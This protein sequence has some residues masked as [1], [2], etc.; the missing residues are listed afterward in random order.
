MILIDAIYINEGGGASLLNFL[1]NELTKK[2][3]NYFVLFDKRINK[4]IYSKLNR[5]NYVILDN[6][7]KSRK[8]F[9][10]TFLVQF[11]LIFCFANVPPPIF[12]KIKTIILCHN[13]LLFSSFFEK[14]NLKF[15][16]KL[17]FLLKRFYI[18]YKNK[19]H[20]YWVVQ[21]QTM[22]KKVGNNFFLRKSQILVI[23]FFDNL[24]ESNVE[25]KKD[26]F[27]F[28][29]VASG[30]AHKN[31]INLLHAWDILYNKYKISPRLSIT[32]SEDNIYLI[33][34]IKRLIKKG[35]NIVNLGISSKNEIIDLYKTTEYLIY[36]SL[37]ESFG[38]PLL[39][40][41]SLDCKVLASDLPYVHDIIIP[42]CLFDPFN[43][44]EIARLVYQ[45]KDKTLDP[46]QLLIF[47]QIDDL[48]NLFQNVSR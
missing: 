36:P 44:S 35:L 22:K 16:S 46:S 6:N 3:I 38:L 13:V 14:N 43:P 40:A 5:E 17:F 18:Y 19:S 4:S 45:I 47:S 26:S 12:I 31:H 24:V 23:P 30:D 48:I 29:Y 11:N 15:K 27:T 9:Y 28:A 8:S 21:T 42:S 37:N 25:L 1:I 39:E 33:D 7:E 20:Y 34:L 32:I 2:N 41:I 10:N